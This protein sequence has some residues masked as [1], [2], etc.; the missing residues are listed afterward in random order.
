MQ[1]LDKPLAL[2]KYI[3]G[4]IDDNGFPPSRRE[5]V[6]GYGISS[7]SVATYYLKA[8]QKHEYIQMLPH[9]SRAIKVL[10]GYN[11]SIDAP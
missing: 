10:R 7:T 1:S 9:R 11:E 6:D 3:E 4:Y 2:L 5:M 8:L